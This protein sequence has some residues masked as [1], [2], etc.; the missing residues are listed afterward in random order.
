VC[1]KSGA[2]GNNAP[3]MFFELGWQLGRQLGW[4]LGCAA[5]ASP[6]SPA[7]RV[8]CRSSHPLMDV[9]LLLRYSFINADQTT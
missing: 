2:F 5:T 4:Q 7:G 8:P 9:E 1:A 6:A 3:G